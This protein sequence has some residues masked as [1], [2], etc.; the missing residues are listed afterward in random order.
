[1]NEIEIC[2]RKIG[3]AYRPLVIAEIGINHEGDI[4][5]AY[6]MVDDA[7]DAGCECVKFQCHIIEDEMI[8]NGVIPC[9]AKESIWDIMSRC[10][11]SKFEDVKLK[12]YVESKG[13]IYLSTPF[14][15][16]AANRLKMMGVAAYK[17]G[18]GECN[19]YP[20]VEHIARFGKPVILS[21]GMNNIASVS[22][23]VD[24]LKKHVVPYAILHCTSIYPTP[25]EKVKLGALSDLRSAFGD[26][27]LG[28]SDHSI[29]NYV[30][31]AAVALGA[32][33]LEKHF[34]SDKNWPGPDV[35]LSIEPA[36]L[37]E[38]IEGT[39]A[40]HKACGGN[41]DILQEEQPTIDFAY[42]CVVSTRAIRAGD[43]FMEDNIW[44]KRPGT[45]QI[46]AA[47]YIN[48]LGKKTKVNIEPNCQIRYCDIV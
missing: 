28:V 16:A 10:K 2:D 34:T 17:I 41:K 12:K 30:S 25:Y 43:R 15:R 6:Q 33:I 24:I 22:R 3:V 5:K 14:S 32:S 11:L 44:V 19:N 27:V 4:N 35:S 8:P 9:N 31:F 36:Q 13:M 7:C 38:L 20:L 45:G 1:M 42:A 48:V 26:V 47:D 21:T 46:K 40:I 23:A 39:E 29:G 18:S 37:R